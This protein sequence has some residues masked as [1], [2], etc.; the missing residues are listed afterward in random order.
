[1]PAAERRKGKRAEL[2]VVNYLKENGWDARTSR[3]ASGMQKGYDIIAN[4]PLAIEV[5][6]HVRLELASWL[7]QARESSG[8]LIPVVWHKKRGSSNPKDWYVT[9]DGDSLMRVMEV[10]K[11]G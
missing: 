2:D 6:D 11:N 7:A 4:L 9:M 1:M 8:D 5:K 10:Y 3:A